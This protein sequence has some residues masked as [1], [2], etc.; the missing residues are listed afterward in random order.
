MQKRSFARRRHVKGRPV[1]KPALRASIGKRAGVASGLLGVL[2]VLAEFC[3]LLPDLLVTKDALPVYAAN[4]RVFRGILE[5]AIFATL[6][7]LPVE[8]RRRSRTLRA[9]RVR[10]FGG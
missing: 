1:L 8:I 10:H 6:A 4:I 9:P 3:F 5:A 2:C 7:A